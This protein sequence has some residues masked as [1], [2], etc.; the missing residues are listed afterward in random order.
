MAM[1]ITKAVALVAMP[2]YIAFVAEP[3]AGGATVPDCEPLPRMVP[4]T[5]VPW[6]FGS[7][8][9][10]PKTVTRPLAKSGWLRSA[11]ESFTLTS[12][13]AA[14]KAEITAVGHGIDR[15][16]QPH[17]RQVVRG[18]PDMRRRHSLH[19]GQRGDLHQR[20]LGRMH[21]QHRP[22]GRTVF[23][24]YVRAQLPQGVE[25]RLTCVR[26]H[27]HVQ[28]NVS[29][30]FLLLHRELQQRLV[31]LVIRL[32]RQDAL[33]FGRKL[34]RAFLRNPHQKSVVRDVGNDG[35]PGVGQQRSKSRV[36]GPAGL[37]EIGPVV[38]RRAQM[39]GN[40]QVG[41]RVSRCQSARWQG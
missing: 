37:D 23:A 26:K 34:L 36:T 12:H 27:N 10:P 35:G 28:R 9:A 14:R 1:G 17:A 2:L 33:R 25:R 20:V 19:A 11:P 4:S 31:Q 18:F 32:I 30:Q 29:R 21:R 8:V 22:E 13:V 5:C 3:L 38:F 15:L 41:Q 6:P 39:S 40:L 16:A 7:V 24:H